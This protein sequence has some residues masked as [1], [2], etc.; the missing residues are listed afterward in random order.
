MRYVLLAT[1]VVFPTV[2][3]GQGRA[4]PKRTRTPVPRFEDFRVPSPIAKRSTEAFL[5]GFD[6]PDETAEHFQGRIREA[7]KKGPDIAGV[8]AFVRMGSG[9]D[10]NNVWVVNIQTGQSLKTPIIGATRCVPFSNGPLFSYRLDSSLLIV[11]GS[12]EVPDAKGSFGDGPCGR[13]YYLVERSGLKLIRS[14]VPLQDSP[15]K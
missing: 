4:D 12:L 8:Y 13:F 7:A 2:G 5:N 15:P 6:E 9:S 3:L 1:L 10:C 11:T 14:V